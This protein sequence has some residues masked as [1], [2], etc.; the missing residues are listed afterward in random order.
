MKKLRRIIFNGLTV[1]S[2]LLCVATTVM[3]FRSY[4]VGDY[5]ACNSLSNHQNTTRADYDTEREYLANRSIEEYRMGSEF[6][7]VWAQH[8]TGWDT[9]NQWHPPQFW[10]G[11]PQPAPLEGTTVL[12]KLGFG[13]HGGAVWSSKAWIVSVPHSALAVTLAVP[14]AVWVA[15]RLRLYRRSRRRARRQC[16]VC[17]YDLRATPNRCPECGSIPEKVKA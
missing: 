15:L 10:S 14:P 7:I 4:G 1:L 17:G 9:F 6:G 8:E 12:G 13:H 5:W 16:P 2:L 11:Y 3:W